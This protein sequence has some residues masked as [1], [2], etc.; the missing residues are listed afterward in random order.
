MPV[1]LPI[2][3]SLILC[4]TTIEDVR[5]KKKSL[6]GL[7][8]QISADKFPY[9]HPKMDVLVTLTGCCGPVPCTITCSE[10]GAEKPLVSINFMVNAKSPRDVADVVL[11]IQSMR[12]PTP[13]LYIFR[14]LADGVPFMMRPINVRQ[15]TARPSTSN[16]SEQS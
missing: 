12:F 4:D 14:V 16:A 2:G 10:D 8:T 13:G 11:S 7:F 3:L 6:I 1:E 9:T 5:T 15:R